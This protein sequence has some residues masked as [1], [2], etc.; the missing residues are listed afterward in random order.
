MLI[1][2]AKECHFIAIVEH[3]S[4]NWTCKRFAVVKI[5]EVGFIVKWRRLFSFWYL[6][7]IDIFVIV[8]HVHRSCILVRIQF[9][10]DNLRK[11][12]FKMWSNWVLL[13]ISCSEC[14]QHILWNRNEYLHKIHS[15]A[16]KENT[17]NIKD[18]PIVTFDLFLLLQILDWHVKVSSEK[19]QSSNDDQN[20]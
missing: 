9:V 7:A 5:R 16:N 12:S 6:C 14:T 4:A 11:F 1:L 3:Y 18:D 19:H 10:R 17:K 13:F 15:W 8:I 20:A 2:A